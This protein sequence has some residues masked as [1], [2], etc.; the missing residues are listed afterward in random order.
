MPTPNK[1]VYLDGIFIYSK[2]KAEHIQ[3]LCR[4][5]CD[6]K[7]SRA[8]NQSEEMSSVET[9][10]KYLGHIIEKKAVITDPSKMEPIRTFGKPKYVKNP[11]SFWSIC[12]RV[13]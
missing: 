12:K 3:I 13:C 5:F 4:V 8:A 9:E 7:R 11:R 2:H 1:T 10:I 6:N